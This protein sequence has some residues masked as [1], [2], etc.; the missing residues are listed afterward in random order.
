M[1]WTL[2]KI[3]EWLLGLNNLQKVIFLGMLAYGSVSLCIGDGNDAKD[4]VPVAICLVLALAVY[5]FKS[6]K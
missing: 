3:N 6:K 1:L 5:L 2:K 4:L